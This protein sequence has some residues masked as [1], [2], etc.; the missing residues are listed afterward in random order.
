MAVISYSGFNGQSKIKRPL[1]DILDTR[2]A[3]ALQPGLFYETSD[4]AEIM[5]YRASSTGTLEPW[6]KQATITAQIAAAV[7]VERD[8]RISNVLILNDNIVNEAF[9][10]DQKDTQLEALI[11][12]EITDR[13]GAVSTLQS[14]LSTLQT[15][16]TSLINQ[17]AADL[18]DTT[19]ADIVKVSY[20]DA[21]ST[22]LADVLGTNRPDGIYSLHFTA[23]DGNANA[24]MTVTGLPISAPGTGDITYGDVLRVKIDG[25]AV[26][27]AD[28]IDDV[29]KAKF[30]AIDT[31]ITDILTQLAALQ[32]GSA[33]STGNMLAKSGNTIKFDGTMTENTSVTGAFTLNLAADKTRISGMLELPM[34]PSDALGMPT[35]W[36]GQTYRRVWVDQN[37]VCVLVPN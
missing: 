4:Q 3:V 1:Q 8:A 24:T 9:L 7:N 35:T 13:T 15:N 6:L 2:D 36:D 22:A 19:V 33:T 20:A 30:N 29:T 27:S 37:S 5:L 12:Q 28:K 16:L 34:I 23:T 25:G 21:D 14:N 26:V 11:N 18:R 17:T 31:Q 32:A 10:R